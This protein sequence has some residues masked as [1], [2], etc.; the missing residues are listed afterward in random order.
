[1]LFRSERAI[2]PGFPILD[3]YLLGNQYNEKFVKRGLIDY[4]F[5]NRTAAE[6]MKK[7]D[8]RA[9]DEKQA[10]GS[11]SGGNQQKM[12]LSREVKKIRILCWYASQYGGWI[13][14]R[15]TIYMKYYWI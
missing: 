9:V 13:S 4:T 5:L 2:L 15:S 11:L 14:V 7:Y 1:M 3:N 8:V 6:S 10:A 12:V